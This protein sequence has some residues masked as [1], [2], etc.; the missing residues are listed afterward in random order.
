MTSQARST[1]GDSVEVRSTGSPLPAIEWRLSCDQP[2]QP[3]GGRTQLVQRL[4]GSEGISAAE[5]APGRQSLGRLS[6]LIGTVHL[7]APID[8]FITPITA[9]RPRHRP[10]SALVLLVFVH[11]RIG[12]LPGRVQ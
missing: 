7:V 2:A 12:D 9:D 3:L 6:R 4:G 1:W 11:G 5:A 10:A 8:G